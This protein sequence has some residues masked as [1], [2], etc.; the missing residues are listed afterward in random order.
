MKQQ[1]PADRLVLGSYAPFY[2][3]ESALLKLKESRLTDAQF[4]A[5]SFKNA[6]AI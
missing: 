1:L 5:I 2:I 3:P 4:N 6:Q